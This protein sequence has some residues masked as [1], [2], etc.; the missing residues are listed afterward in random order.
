MFQ[1]LAVT[2]TYIDNSVNEFLNSKSFKDW[3]LVTFCTKY[4]IEFE[5]TWSLRNSSCCRL[6]LLSICSLWVKP[7]HKNHLLTNSSNKK[8][9]K[10]SKLALEIHHKKSRIFSSFWL[11]T[12]AFML[13]FCNWIYKLFW[14]EDQIAKQ[15]FRLTWL[16]VIAPWQQSRSSYDPGLALN[17]VKVLFWLLLLS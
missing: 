17:Q 14:S 2:N 10:L 9:K 8:P 13:H 5:C 3:F 6:L 4:L 11:K 16:S 7:K 15:R 12:W 1:I